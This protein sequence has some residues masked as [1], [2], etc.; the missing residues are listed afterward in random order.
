[1]TIRLK[2]TEMNWKWKERGTLHGEIDEE[3]RQ[4]RMVEKKNGEKRRRIRKRNRIN[5]EQT[6]GIYRE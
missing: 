3:E 5:Q 4:K 6:D 1:M 2:R